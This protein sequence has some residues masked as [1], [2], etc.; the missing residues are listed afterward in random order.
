VSDLLV[1]E[2]WYA[3]LFGAEAV[4]DEDTGPF[5][6]VVSSCAVAWPSGCTCT[7]MATEP[8]G[9]T[10]ASPGSTTWRS[11][12][13]TVLSLKQWQARF[14]DLGVEHGGIINA[15][16]GSV[17]AFKDPDGVVLEFFAPAAGRPVRVRPRNL[18]RRF[19]G[20]VANQLVGY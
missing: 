7:V 18:G 14:D 15:H 9:S 3:R 4:L 19:P 10:R 17:V 8:M 2:P 12:A 11:A 1:S 20:I 13:P 5:R 6:H 16:H